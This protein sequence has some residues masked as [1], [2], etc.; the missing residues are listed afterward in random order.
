[1]VPRFFVGLLQVRSRLI[2]GLREIAARPA[3]AHTMPKN[4][5]QKL[6]CF[7][8][9]N[10][11]SAKKCLSG[12]SRLFCVSTH[13]A[14]NWVPN[15]YDFRM[16]TRTK[17]KNDSWEVDGFWVSACSLSKK[18]LRCLQ[19]FGCRH[20]LCQRMV[21]RSLRELWWQHA[22]CHIMVLNGSQDFR[23]Q[24]A[25]YQEMIS[26]MS[27]F[28]L[29]RYGQHALCHKILRNDLQTSGCQ[30]ALCQQTAP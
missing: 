19:N 11:Y 22:F 12:V 18:S 2:W 28:V 7:F 29:R 10:T 25:L 23:C 1:M 15:V 21:I 26:K 16:S 8:G 13:S 14:R 3:S 4:W 9:F 17:Q 27:R 5:L 24:H 6:C 20:A 30:H